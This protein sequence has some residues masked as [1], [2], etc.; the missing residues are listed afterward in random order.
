M[1]ILSRFWE[2]FCHCCINVFD[3]VL[4]PW[5]M[6]ERS[7]I[8]WPFARSSV[9]RS[10]VCAKPAVKVCCHST[11]VKF[12]AE[13]PSF[14]LSS[15]LNLL[16][17]HSRKCKLV[18]VGG[19]SRSATMNCINYLPNT[20]DFEVMRI[21]F[22]SGRTGCSFIFFVWFFW[23]FPLPMVLMWDPWWAVFEWGSR[24][25]WHTGGIISLSQFV[26]YI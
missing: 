20:Y 21:S 24:V 6:F 2:F 5:W 3:C 16:L 7:G 15:V 4:Q 1:Y 25:N 23:Q 12:V 18:N 26:N 14:L 17:F 9:L 8:Y 11:A 10:D 22:V 13:R 19:Q